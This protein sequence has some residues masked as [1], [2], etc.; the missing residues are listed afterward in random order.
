M[1]DMFSFQK[2]LNTYRRISSEL[3][4]K[5]VNICHIIT[6]VVVLFLPHPTNVDD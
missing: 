4:K 6:L 5:Q 3:N 2:Y 1:K